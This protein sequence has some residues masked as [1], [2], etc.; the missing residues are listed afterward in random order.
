LR[1]TWSLVIRHLAY[2]TRS[3][4]FVLK[5]SF[6]FDLAHLTFTSSTWFLRL[7]FYDFV[8][9]ALLLDNCNCRSWLR[10]NSGVDDVTAQGSRVTN[11]TSREVMRRLTTLDENDDIDDAVAKSSV[12]CWIPTP[13][14]IEAE[15]MAWPQTQQSC[16]LVVPCD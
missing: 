12:Y 5:S 10:L 7:G 9:T 6:Y 14:L 1:A 3:H 8:L 15:K 16:Q 4:R 2:A 13:T 11:I